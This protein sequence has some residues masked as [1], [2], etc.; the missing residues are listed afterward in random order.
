MP[1]LSITK[2]RL[3]NYRSFKML[4][5]DFHP[6]LTVLIA[7]NGIGKTAILD[8]LAVAFGPYVGAFDEA[9]GTHFHA[10]DIRL[11]RVRVTQ[12]NE[13]EYAPNGVTLEATGFIPE[14]E[15]TLELKEER[16]NAAWK[17]RLA[18]P[19]KAKTT[20]KEAGVLIRY[21][22]RQQEA[23][24]QGED[25][26][27]PLL[28]Y[29]GTG[30]LWQQKKLTEAK[31]PRSSRTLGYTDCLDPASSYKSLTEWF[32]YWSLN[33][34]QA[35]LAASETS[36]LYTPTEFD[37][38][39]HSVADAVNT[40]LAPAG[41][42][43]LH[44]SFAQ[45]TLVARHAQYGTL[46]VELLSDGIRN[47]L[48]MVA[49]IAFRAT[50]LNPQLGAA[51]AKTTPGVVLIDEVD[52]HLHPEWQQS[53]LG[54][55]TQAFPQVQFIVTTHSPQILSSVDMRSIRV[56]HHIISPET[57]QHATVVRH[58]T[59]QTR[60][61]SSADVLAQI[62]GI[63]PIPN[64]P[65]AKQLQT[66]HALIQQNRHHTPEGCTCQS[67]LIAHFGERH[68]ALEACDRMIRLQ[69][70]KQQHSRPKTES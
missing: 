13:M 62:M 69:A 70:I 1:H 10:N 63:D 21:G 29:Y 27:L 6:Q 58:V 52:T 37:H 47:M 22:K 61:V 3:E 48:C 68:P 39:I 43:E 34:L 57:A 65:E 2:L 51:A 56:L 33:A 53:V 19:T 14:S 66:Y 11:S 59:Q 64:V 40:C 60:G 44:Y 55:L 46:P 35:K 9:V 25:V 5:I 18:S 31:L 50:K 23:V 41:W 24:R 38:Y 54:S 12:S 49:D 42:A 36:T 17:R 15:P 26:V 8:A 30:R 20:I 32:R 28:A 7:A 4:E 67:Q 16:V 45:E